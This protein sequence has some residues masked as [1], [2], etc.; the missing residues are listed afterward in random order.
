MAD[1]LERLRRPEEALRARAAA[2]AF[3][4]V[5]DLY[6]DHP[7]AR[8]LLQRSVLV[9]YEQLPEVVEAGSPDRRIVGPGEGVR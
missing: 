4:T 6:A 5:E 3:V 8:A 7:F 1:L 9:A 2:D